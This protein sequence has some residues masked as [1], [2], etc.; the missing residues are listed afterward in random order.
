MERIFRLQRLVAMLFLVMTIAVFVFSLF[1]MTDFKDLFGL[2]MK[3]NEDVAYFHDTVLQGYNQQI[4]L[5]A[6]AGLVV[7]LVFFLLQAFSRVPDVFALVIMTVCCIALASFSVYAIVSTAELESVYLSLDYS[8]VAMEGGFDYVVRTRTF[9]A[10]FVINGL[11]VAV[12]AAMAAIMNIS[13][14]TFVRKCKGAVYA[15][16]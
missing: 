3:L 5:A 7:L 8:H 2:M 9:T 11:Y 4:F 14:F 16:A 6:V 1:F 12:C 13:H 15:E 10:S